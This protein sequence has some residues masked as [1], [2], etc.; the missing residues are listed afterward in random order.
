MIPAPLSQGLTVITDPSAIK[1]I[2]QELES[3]LEEDYLYL[4]GLK[5]RILLHSLT[6]LFLENLIMQHIFV[7]KLYRK[8]QKKT[9]YC[10]SSKKTKK[11]QYP[12]LGMEM[13]DINISLD[14]SQIRV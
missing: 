2:D 6:T 7:H 3:H 9:N 14:N 13:S 1:L 4:K 10:Q 8:M 11:I 5:F 12:N